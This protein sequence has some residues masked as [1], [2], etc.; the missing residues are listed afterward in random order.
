[1]SFFGENP[2]CDIIASSIMAILLFVVYS[3]ISMGTD[4][5]MLK[6]SQNIIAGAGDIFYYFNLKKL[7]S[8]CCFNFLLGLR[9]LFILLF[10]SVP[11]VICAFVFYTLSDNGFSAAVCIIFAAFTVIFIAAELIAYVHISDTFFMTR[12]MF[13]KGEYFDFKHLFA[14]SQ[15]EMVTHIKRLRHLRISFTGWFVLSILI[16]P[17]PYVWGYYRQSKACLAQEIMKS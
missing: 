12:Y 7:F 4:R 13:I 6:R 9:K 15:Q 5:F 2:I 11:A 17:L 3:A 14:V 10:L 1:M 16:F 8:L